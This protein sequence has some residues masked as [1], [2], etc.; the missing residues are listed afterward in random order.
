M[1]RQQ[2]PQVH[3]ETFGCQ[4]NEYDSELVRSLLTRDGFVFTDD[5]ERADVILMNTCA[6]RENAH[7]KVYTH[8]SDLRALKRQRPLVVGV[9]GCMA[10]N[11]KEELA[12][13]EP[14]VDVLA[15][16]DSYRHLPELIT[17][18]MESQEQGELRRQM[19]VDLSEYET[20]D[21]VAPD[22]RDGVNAWIAVMRGCDNFCSFC[23]VPYTRGRERSREPEGIVAEARLAAA[24]GFK[25]IT[26]LGQNVN[27][28]RCGDWD[29]ARL[30]VAVADVPGIERVRFTSPHPKDFPPSLLDAV[31]SHPKICKHIHLPVQSG[32]DRILGLMNRT[33]SRS[34][35]L[36]LVDQIRSSAPDIVLTTDVI[37][38][39]CSE[40]DEE[41]SDTYRLLEEV[42]YH[43]AFIFKYSERK[44]TIAARKWP[45]D[46]PETVKSERVTALADLQ[47]RISHERNRAYLGTTLSVLVEGDA[48]RSSLQSKGKSDGN[49]TVVWSKESVP[50]D[51]GQMVRLSVY[52]CSASTL[53]A[54]S[55]GDRACRPKSV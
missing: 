48:K 28:Y 4:M 14:L 49:I 54:A 17:K 42:R 20:Y 8:L 39:F 9:L 32:N 46:V 45:D 27:S 11:L 52:D 38:G 41:F 2:P 43:A 47:R 19:A 1:S 35:Y 7:N 30:L 24:E 10:Q 50:A 51:P 12:E 53:Y 25:Q 55:T 36:S 44:N 21:D 31:V 40:S 5:R 18:A 13:K 33:Y 3:L 26:L 29:F 34:A 16:P 6:I 23:V 22:R 15:G 37:A